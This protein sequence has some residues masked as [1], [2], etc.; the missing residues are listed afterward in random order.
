MYLVVLDLDG[1]VHFI[2]HKNKYDCLTICGECVEIKKNNFICL[3]NEIEHLCQRCKMY[4]NLIMGRTDDP[5]ARNFNQ[6]DIL[7]KAEILED[8][9]FLDKNRYEAKLCN[10]NWKLLNKFKHSSKRNRFLYE[11]K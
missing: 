9:K 3:D 1:I 6:Q 4:Q 7:I 2:D 11:K 8:R 10:R 5:L